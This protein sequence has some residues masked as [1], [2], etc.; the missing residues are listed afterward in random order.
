M[1]GKGIWATPTTLDSCTFLRVSSKFSDQQSCHIFRE[2]PQPDYVGLQILEFL[3][4]N[5]RIKSQ[6]VQEKE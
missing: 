2:E 5:D 1:N 3:L 4:K 6:Y